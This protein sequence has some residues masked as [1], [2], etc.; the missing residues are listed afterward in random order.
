MTN[1]IHRRLVIVSDGHWG[2]SSQ[3][4]QTLHNQ[5]LDRIHQIHDEREV[6]ALIH[7]GDIV[8]DDETLHQAVIDNFFDELPIGVDWYPVFGNHDWTT[9]EEWEDIYG[10]PKD[11][12]FEVGDYGFV[13]ADCG[14]PRDASSRAPAD[15]DWIEQQIDSFV[16]NGKEGVFVCCHFPHA[17]IGSQSVGDDHPE[18]A[19]E[20]RQ[21][22]KRDDVICCFTGHWH[23]Q[24]GIISS[25]EF[26]GGRW[27][28]PC[29]IGGSDVVSTWGQE[30]GNDDQIEELG[31]RVFDI[32]EKS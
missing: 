8:H 23:E 17:D 18:E 20:F 19:E 27:V 24:N 25:H 29:R 11:Y 4:S 16:S 21:Q 2:Q 30:T 32:S 3:D 22:I 28:F 13:V 12:T 26:D 6:D 14:D 15:V 5:A 1:N 9:D 7:A 31:I 10:I